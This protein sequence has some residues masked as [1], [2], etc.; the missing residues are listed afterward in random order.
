M[1]DE[2]IRISD[3]CSFRTL[4]ERI[5]FPAYLE[6]EI[7]SI[8]CN[9]LLTDRIN[10]KFKAF[11][12]RRGL[13]SYDSVESYAR[14]V[15]D[16]E[17]IPTE[18]NM[19]ISD[20]NVTNESWNEFQSYYTSNRLVPVEAFLRKNGIYAVAYKVG[21]CVCVHIKRL[22]RIKLG[23]VLSIIPN[24][25]KEYFQD[26][27]LNETEIEMLRC[28][29]VK[30]DN[31]KDRF[32]RLAKELLN[33]FDFRSSYIHSCLDGY[34]TSSKKKAIESLKT[35]I[36]TLV[37]RLDHYRDNI[38]DLYRR[39]SAKNDAYNGMLMSIKDKV[40]NDLAE[41]FIRNKN[42]I[43]TEKL[44][45]EI[46]FIV[47]GYMENFNPDAYIAV[48]ENGR[49]KDSC[50]FCNE[51]GYLWNESYSE[52]VVK[53]LFDRV[54]IDMDVKLKI[55]AAYSIDIGTFSLRGLRYYQYS[56]YGVID[57]VP[58]AH[59]DR[60][61]CLGSN[62][63]LMYEAMS[64]CDV[65]TAVSLCNASA[66]SI[67]ISESVT[68]SVVMM[69][70]YSDGYKCFEFPDGKCYS[71]SEAYDIVCKSIEESSSKE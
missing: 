6:S 55:C 16:R 1:F 58:N 27:P 20:V 65:M 61:S 7:G 12:K 57:S 3:V 2:I 18:A 21:E 50:F 28:L 4:N 62:E 47:D 24:L 44:D 30:G 42:L 49:F 41:Y 70:I 8:V 11:V 19:F 66:Q 45:S 34:E 32:I 15:F 60:Y 53:A 22:S 68:F 31:N 39:I 71:M 14:R 10:S 37:E 56:D 69:N 5:Y 63:E 23:V 54:F 26:K 67:N 9:I 29:A 43:L 51:D 64:N 35:E 33:G 38:R 46:R 40:E 36:D 59:I 48:K 25:F 52:E 17:L 13:R